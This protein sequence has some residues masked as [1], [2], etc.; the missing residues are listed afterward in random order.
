M[1]AISEYG[2]DIAGT[3]TNRPTKA[4]TGQHYFDTT[5]GDWLVWNGTAW[6]SASSPTGS[7]LSAT[8]ILG[9]DLSLGI[10]GATGVAGV[11]SGVGGAVPVAGG[12]GATGTT[13]T[14]GGVGGAAS[15]TSGAGGAKTGT[16]AAAG[17]AG[18]A[19][20]LVSGAGGATASSGTDAG[21]AAGT[22]T[23]TGGVGGAATAGTGN[24]GA[25]GSINLVPGAGGASAG[26]TAGAA[27]EVKINGTAGMSPVSFVYG[28]DTPLDCAFFVADRAYRVKSITVRPLVV[29]SDGGAV[30]AEVRK[31]ASGVAADSGT[32][33]HTGT[34]DLKG[35]INTNQALTLSTTPATVALAA[36]D[37]L[38]IDVTGTTTAARGV[39]TVGL[40]PI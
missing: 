39:I 18:G 9:S 20:A 8:A 2:C 37:A 23:I 16:G 14:A 6:Q 35:T 12:A 15:L 19:A 11:S 33:L 29:G 38:C 31:A 34:A 26:G 4:S 36:G 40:V 5:T 17:G 24:G 1:G 22:V 10:T 28:E 25:G 32:V 27:G 30:T 3:T 7:T 21:G 13:T